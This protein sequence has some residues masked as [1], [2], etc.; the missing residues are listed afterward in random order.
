[1]FLELAVLG[2]NG[3]FNRLLKSFHLAIYMCRHG[4][5]ASLNELV[6]SHLIVSTGVNKDL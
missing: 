6:K 5:K 2:R 4:Q 1:M 3:S